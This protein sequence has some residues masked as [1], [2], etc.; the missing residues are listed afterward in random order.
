MNISLIIS[1]HSRLA[2]GA[3][4]LIK[5]IFFYVAFNFRRHFTVFRTA[6]YKREEKCACVGYVASSNEQL[7]SQHRPVVR[8]IG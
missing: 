2:I 1:L 5:P 6:G 7:E 8:H 4:R 3:L